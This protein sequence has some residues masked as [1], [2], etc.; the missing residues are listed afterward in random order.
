MLDLH[1]AASMQMH[2]SNLESLKLSAL[3]DNEGGNDSNVYI[4]DSLK[5]STQEEKRNEGISIG[6]N[7]VLQDSTEQFTL[8]CPWVETQCT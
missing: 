4:P 8:D 5:E 6:P 2:F 3:L 1:I 7:K